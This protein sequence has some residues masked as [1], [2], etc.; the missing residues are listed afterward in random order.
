MPNAVETEAKIR[1][2]GK[3]LCRAGW[4]LFA[5]SMLMPS[6]HMGFGEPLWM[7]GWECFRIV[8]EGLFK[9][10]E[11]GVGSDW[12]LRGFGVMNLAMLASPFLVRLKRSDMRWLRR[13]GLTMAAV[14]AYVLSLPFYDGSWKSLGVGYYAWLLSFGLVT[15]GTL[16]QAVKRPNRVFNRASTSVGYSEEEMMALRELEQY[17]RGM[18]TIN[19]GA[20]QGEE[21]KPSDTVRDFGYEQPTDVPNMDTNAQRVRIRSRRASIPRS[22]MQPV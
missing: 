3:W 7:S 17:I 15:V 5:V 18:S 11:Q 14:T 10:G 19:E 4:G 20:K 2:R 12:Y 1:K 6:F 9:P 22:A 13:I 8:L 21:R 16:H